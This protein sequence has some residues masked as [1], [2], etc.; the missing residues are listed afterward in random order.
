MELR[1]FEPLTFSLRRLGTGVWQR[2]LP[3]DRVHGV[4]VDSAH[5][6]SG[7]AGGPCVRYVEPYEIGVYS[8]R[9]LE[10]ARGSFGAVVPACPH[11]FA[12]STAARCDRPGVNAAAES[13]DGRRGQRAGRRALRSGWADWALHWKAARDGL[14]DDSRSREHSEILSRSCTTGEALMES[15]T[16][17]H[18]ATRIRDHDLDDSTGPGAGPGRLSTRSG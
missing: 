4:P 17:V 10:P 2:Q 6:E 9:P 15:V 7:Y 16:S 18:C 12:G 1:G 8:V 3:V 5:C 11:V 13:L 14:L